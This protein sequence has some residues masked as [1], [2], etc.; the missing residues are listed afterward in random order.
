MFRIIKKMVGRE[1][2]KCKCWECG[3][4]CEE[5]AMDFS[6]CYETSDRDGNEIMLA[7]CKSCKDID[8]LDIFEPGTLKKREL[9]KALSK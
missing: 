6:I 2:M 8:V 4:F 9:E 7:I 5:E 1:K 3:R